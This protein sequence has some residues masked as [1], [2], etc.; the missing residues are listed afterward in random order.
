MKKFKN[1][2]Y[3][4]IKNLIIATS[5]FMV[6]S[7][8]AACKTNVNG[9]VNQLI[10]KLES[11]SHVQGGKVS[12]WINL[13]KSKQNTMRAHLKAWQGLKR[14][15]L[16]YGAAYHWLGK[17][18]SFNKGGYNVEVK[19]PGR[20]TNGVTICPPNSKFKAHKTLMPIC[21][22]NSGITTC[23]K[24]VITLCAPQKGRILVAPGARKIKGSS[25]KFARKPADG[26]TRAD[27]R[28]WRKIVKTVKRSWVALGGGAKESSSMISLRFEYNLRCNK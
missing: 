15:K 27:K 8:H 13:P 3:H 26:K 24:G 18:Y 2:T 12:Y 5:A 17:N 21:Q 14:L 9:V 4:I 19:T 20:F 28:A 6:L 1:I 11:K 10:K 16:K 25:I 7:A 23:T 22:T